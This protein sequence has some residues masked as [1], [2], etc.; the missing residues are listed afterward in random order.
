MFRYV[1]RCKKGDKMGDKKLEHTENI[2]KM[3]A[4]EILANGNT[5]KMINKE[6]FLFLLNLIQKIGIK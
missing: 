5:P 3:R 1:N 4:Y 2:R 6:T